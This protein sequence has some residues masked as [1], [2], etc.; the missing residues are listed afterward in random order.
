MKQNENIKLNKNIE[1]NLSS[2][3]MKVKICINFIIVFQNN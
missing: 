3:I 1:N 2:L